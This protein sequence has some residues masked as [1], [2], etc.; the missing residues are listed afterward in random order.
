[1][2]QTV[3]RLGDI[4]GHKAEELIHLFAMAIRPDI[5]PSA[6]KDDIFAFPTSSSVVKNL[7]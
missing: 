6:I 4:G 5:P 7:F 2:D 1:M 3:R